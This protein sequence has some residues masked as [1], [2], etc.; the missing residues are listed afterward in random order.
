MAAGTVSGILALAGFLSSLFGGRGG[1]TGTANIDPGQQRELINQQLQMFR[2]LFPQIRNQLLI[3]RTSGLRNLFMTDPDFAKAIS[4]SLRGLGL[5]QDELGGL[6]AGAVPLK[7]AVNNLAYGLLP[8]FAR[9]SD[10][11]GTAEQRALVEASP[12]RRIDRFGRPSKSAAIKAYLA[13][14]QGSE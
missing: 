10:L 8:R 3:D 4:P 5:T 1:N 2:E 9:A 7:R 6:S 11:A 12:R 14:N 13:R